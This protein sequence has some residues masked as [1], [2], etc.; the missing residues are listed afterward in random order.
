MAFGKPSQQVNTTPFEEALA[1]ERKWNTIWRRRQKAKSKGLCDVS[2]SGQQ[3]VE[4]VDKT[5]GFQSSGKTSKSKDRGVF[6]DQQKSVGAER[7]MDVG[8]Q[9]S[10][11]LKSAFSDVEELTP[12]VGNR[13]QNCPC[14]GQ[15][16]LINRQVPS[17]L[18]RTTK[19][20][21]NCST[22]GSLTISCSKTTSRALLLRVEH[23]EA[24]KSIKM[25]ATCWH[26]VKY[27]WL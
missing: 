3:G 5:C 20:P 17:Q 25:A 23:P 21:S 7:C 24:A 9:A 18:L 13:P 2:I 10:A 27:I 16:N 19:K 22:P 26:P 6:T 11:I 1:N 8:R 4:R 15:G 12:F 14:C